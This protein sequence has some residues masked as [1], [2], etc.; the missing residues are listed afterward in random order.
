MKTRRSKTIWVLV[1]A[2][3][4][5]LLG[6]GLLLHRLGAR[7]SSL[8]ESVVDTFFTENTD[9]AGAE[10]PDFDGRDSV[11][12]NGNR[13]LFT[14]AERSA[15]PYVSFS[16]FD[17]LGRTGAGTA[18]LGP[19]LLPTKE[20]GPVGDF[21]PSGW[22]T[23]RY[24]DLIEDHFLY[25]RCHVIGYLLCGDNA[26]PENLFTGTRYLNSSSMLEYE[27]KVSYYIH[28][29]GNHVAYRVTPEYEGKNLVATGVRMEAWSIEDSGKGL[30]F[31]VFV[32]NIQPGII[33]DYRTGDSRRAG[34]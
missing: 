13:P 32:Y 30:C 3:A 23:V 26:T 34:Q 1:L 24:D 19:E 4:V 16:A 21:R 11:T 14:E 10:I 12:L 31:H 22:H 27:M 7:P 15:K 2:L 8:Y 20:R 18:M 25:N 9:A 29:T 33:I 17:D 5:L 28:R 6:A